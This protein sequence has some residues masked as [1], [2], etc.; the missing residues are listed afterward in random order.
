[1]WGRF[2][3]ESISRRSAGKWTQGLT[4]WIT[5]CCTVFLWT[6]QSVTFHKYSQLK[7]RPQLLRLW[8][9]IIYVSV[10]HLRVCRQKKKNPPLLSCPST[11]ALPSC[12]HHFHFPVICLQLAQIL[13]TEENFLLCFRQFVSSSAEFMA[14]SVSETSCGLLMVVLSFPLKH[15]STFFFPAEA[16]CWMWILFN[17]N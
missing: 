5:I 11:S 17:Q 12:S 3:A 4:A 15:F 13:P 1:M 6:F 8:L 16:S 7:A 14:V 9:F 10:A 2:G